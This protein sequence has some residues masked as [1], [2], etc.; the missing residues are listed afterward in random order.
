[1]FVCVWALQQ[2][3]AEEKEIPD[4]K[5]ADVKGVDE[6]KEELE[7]IVDYLKVQLLLVMLYSIVVASWR[8]PLFV[9]LPLTHTVFCC[10]N[11]DSMVKSTLPWVPRSPRAFS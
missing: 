3:F 11:I 10:Y 5:F 6:A 8:P 4:T 7:H 9:S 2:G 1:M